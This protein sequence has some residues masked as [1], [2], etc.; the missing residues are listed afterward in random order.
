MVKFSQNDKLYCS[1]PCSIANTIDGVSYKIAN[2]EKLDEL[3][4][5]FRS[6]PTKYNQLLADLFDI[7]KLVFLRWN[8]NLFENVF[9][10]DDYSQEFMTR[11]PHVFDRIVQAFIDG[12]EDYII[13]MFRYEL[14]ALDT[15]DI[16]PKLL[17]V[18]VKNWTLIEDYLLQIDE[19]SRNQRQ[20]LEYVYDIV[21]NQDVCE[22]WRTKLITFARKFSATLQTHIIW[23]FFNH[24]IKWC[25]FKQTFMPD[26]VINSGSKMHIIEKFDDNRSDW[27]DIK[28]PDDLMQI[29]E[30]LEIALDVN[31]LT[32]IHKRSGKYVQLL[33]ALSEYTAMK[34]EQ[35]SKYLQSMMC[36]DI[37]NMIAKMVNYNCFVK[38]YNY[39]RIHMFVPYTGSSLAF[40][41][42]QKHRKCFR[43]YVYNMET[44]K[45]IKGQWIHKK[46]YVEE[47]IFSLDGRLM[48][49]RYRCSNQFDTNAYT[50]IS[51]TPNFTASWIDSN[52]S[53][54]PFEPCTQE[55]RNMMEDLHRTLI[56]QNTQH[57][58]T[59]LLTK[60]FPVN[61]KWPKYSQIVVNNRHVKLTQ[62]QVIF[63]NELLQAII[64]DKFRHPQLVEANLTCSKDS[65]VDIIKFNNEFFSL[66][67][68]ATTL[69]HRSA[70]LKNVDPE[71]DDDEADDGGVA[72]GVGHGSVVGATAVHSFQVRI[73][74]LYYLNLYCS[75][76]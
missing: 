68:L 32:Y 11:L 2:P 66:L 58:M 56:P 5:H 8:S 60:K 6:K 45:L 69:Q 30:L 17:N 1:L 37:S 74:G 27:K 67:S 76:P 20:I 29:C 13:H 53:S 63:D 23:C 43:L 55:E 46:L 75:C 49:Y 54:Q 4:T 47:T 14:F 65:K 59:S 35:L 48:R 42:Y 21:M 9:V 10:G 33:N 73:I 71:N 7:F 18:Q 57:K 24:P 3:I 62:H 12:D 64:W 61:P 34:Q 31:V 41:L 16:L 36:K 26:F 40:F 15:L 72:A 22:E 50:C 25:R 39:S 38:L 51:R 44:K 28:Y 19:K 52:V 70:D